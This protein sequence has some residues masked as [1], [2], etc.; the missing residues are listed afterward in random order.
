M[1]SS[2]V[3]EYVDS[4]ISKTNSALDAGWVMICGALV[5]L[6]RVVEVNLRPKGEHLRGYREIVVHASA[7]S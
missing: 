5:R 2:E 7:L 6:S 4:E 1:V 3:R